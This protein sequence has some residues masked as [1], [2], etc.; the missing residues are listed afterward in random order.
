MPVRVALIVP[1]A[2]LVLVSTLAFTAAAQRTAPQAG[3]ASPVATATPEPRLPEGDE[4]VAQIA[5]TVFPTLSPRV[6]PVARSVQLPAM[7]QAAIVAIIDAAANEFGQDPAFML[8][9]AT[10]ESSLNQ[11]AVGAHGELGIFQFKQPTWTRNAAILGYGPGD[12]WDV[13]AQARV[14]AE[15]FRRQQHWQW[16][17]AAKGAGTPSPAP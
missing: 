10:C 3:V 5:P 7:P 16:T 9:V 8:R 2:T 13:H 11:W 15:M 12:I 1:F 14:A 17:C 4:P 6:E